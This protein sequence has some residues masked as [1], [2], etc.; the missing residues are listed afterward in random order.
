MTLLSTLRCRHL[1]AIALV[2]CA[3]LA[4]IGVWRAGGSHAA[5]AQDKSQSEKQRLQERI[6][7]GVGSEVRF[8]TA[9]DSD[10]DIKASI[11]SV[12]RFI[13]SR[14]NMTM[15]DET[16]SDLLKAETKTLRGERPRIS[17]DALTDSLTALAAERVGTLNEREIEAVANTFRSTSDGQI[18]VRMA[19]NLGLVPRDEFVKGARAAR[20]SMQRGE[21]ESSIRPLFEFQVTDRATNLSEAMPEQFGRITAEGVTPAQAVLIAYSV[22][23]DDS[24]ADSQTDLARHIAQERVNTRLTRAE[25]KAQRLNSPTPYGRNGFFYA[26]PVQL[27]FNRG[28]V[29]G[30]L[31]LGEGGKGK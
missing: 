12:A 2:S 27:L 29:Q 26:S 8:S 7:K 11:E 15:S 19:G 9:T 1:V 13:H 22:A 5:G 31:N 10:D 6:R 24:L 4:A 17:I 25:A 23:A 20:E 16:K 21:L 28:A 30:V 18:T 14:S 3:G